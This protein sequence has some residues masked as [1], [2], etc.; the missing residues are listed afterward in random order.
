MTFKDIKGE[1]VVVTPKLAEKW[2]N[3]SNTENRKLRPGIAEKYA[4][5]MAAG[6]WKE[7][8]QPIIFRDDGVLADGQHRLFAVIES[9]CSIP[10]FVMRGLSKETILN[11]DTGYGRS[12]VDNATIAGWV[13]PISHLAIA[14]AT[15]VH[16]GTRQLGRGLSNAERLQLLDKY[17]PHLVWAESNIP[18]RAKIRN[19]A[20]AAAIARAHI[21]ERN[22]ERLSEFCAI[23]G[24]EI[25][26]DPKADQAAHVFR[27][28][29]LENEDLGR[30]PRDLFLKAMNAIKYFMRRQPLTVIK[31][32]KDEAYPLP[33]K[34][35]EAA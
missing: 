13:G 5:D 34:K 8:P 28:Y 23:L 25:P 7:N 21:H 31:G 27:S 24:G 9:G 15:I 30:D 35:R 3:E 2:L 14:M 10:F 33:A 11:L 1:W 26:R 19:A 12:L 4:V 18:G 20:I 29:A 32:I 17:G 16:Y 6:N 22:L